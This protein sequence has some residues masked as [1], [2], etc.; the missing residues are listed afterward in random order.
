MK[1]QLA[2]LETGASSKE[3]PIKA[4]LPMYPLK[5]TGTS[6]PSLSRRATPKSKHSPLDR[7]H[8]NSSGRWSEVSTTSSHGSRTRR[9]TPNGGH[10]VDYGNGITK[11]V[12]PDG[13]T[14]TRFVNGDVETRFSDLS[15][16]NGR[17]RK[18][19]VAYFHNREGVLQ[20]TQKDGSVLYEY[21]NGQM[22][23]H[24]RDGT[25]VVLFPDGSKTIVTAKQ[26]SI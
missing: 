18:G 16:P 24:L 8:V 19:I 17:E 9:K 3:R 11:E 20:I 15:T 6:F 23:R 14:V 10:V 7:Y 5:P 13:T 21:S 22:E 25:K 12:H 1:D 4:R 26:S 2:L